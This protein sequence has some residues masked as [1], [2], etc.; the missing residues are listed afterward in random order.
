MSFW[1]SRALTLAGPATPRL[2]AAVAVSLALHVVLAFVLDAL[3]RG[4]RGSEFLAPP[5]GATPF[6]VWLGAAPADPAPAPVSAGE[7]S[8]TTADAQPPTALPPLLRYYT[9]RELDVRPGI[10]VHVNPEYP[11]AAM[12]RF[13][14]GTVVVQLYLDESG[15]VERVVTV[16]AEPRGYFEQAAERAF[17]TARFTPG[18]KGGRP[19]KV[20][21]QLEVNFDSAP[22]PG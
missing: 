17:R 20:R 22:P 5:P 9:T 4:G 8:G 2:Y 11:E 6:R 15:R 3:P 14:S 1:S 19:V 21:M 13:L 12:R 10:M 7:G 18:I 16:R